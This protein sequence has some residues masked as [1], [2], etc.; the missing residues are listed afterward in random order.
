MANA[1]LE[2]LTER[3]KEITVSYYEYQ[4]RINAI[5]CRALK[6]EYRGREENYSD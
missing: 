2:I 6:N 4:K 3:I 5:G 1:L